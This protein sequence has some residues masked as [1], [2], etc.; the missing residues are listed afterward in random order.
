FEAA[1]QFD[2]S[3]G[4]LYLWGPWGVG[5]THLA[6]AVLRRSFAR[7]S[8]AL[9]TPA[10]LVR[11]LRME[12]P[13]DEQHAIDFFIGVGVLAIDDLGVGAE[14]SYARQVIQEILDGRAF[15]DRGGLVV[16]S[17]FS[18]NTLARRFNDRAIPSRLTGMC[19]VIEV[20]GSDGRGPGAS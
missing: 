6:V 16:T 20:K 12:T 13:D 11:K 15:K 4:N 18:L 2:A 1:Q 5:K 9:V 7:A 14:T 3:R 19:C 17:P 10:Q 8:A